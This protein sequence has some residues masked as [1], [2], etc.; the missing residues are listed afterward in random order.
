MN[1]EIEESDGDSKC[2]EENH[3]DG[4]LTDCL[5]GISEATANQIYE[6]AGKKLNIEDY[7]QSKISILPRPLVMRPCE[8]VLINEAKIDLGITCMLEIFQIQ[9]ILGLSNL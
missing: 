8:E 2:E 5:E 6:E 4:L 7:D 9:A 1:V 3:H